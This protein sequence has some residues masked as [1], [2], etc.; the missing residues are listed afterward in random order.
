MG[1]WICNDNKNE[2]DLILIKIRD[3]NTEISTA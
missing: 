1:K 2:E 3:M